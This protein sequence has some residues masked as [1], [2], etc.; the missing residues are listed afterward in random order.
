[1]VRESKQKIVFSGQKLLIKKVKKCIDV[2]A[3]YV[4]K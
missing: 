2:A 3:E 4:E 1:M